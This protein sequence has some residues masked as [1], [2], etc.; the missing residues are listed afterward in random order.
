MAIDAENRERI[1]RNIKKLADGGA[2]REK[3]YEY[4]ASEGV[5]AEEVRAKKPGKRALKRSVFQ[6]IK[7]NL[8][9]VTASQFGERAITTGAQQR[10]GA[11]QGLRELAQGPY[12]AVLEAREALGLAEQGRAAD[13][14]RRVQEQRAGYQPQS[15]AESVSRFV[16]PTALTAPIPGGSAARAGLSGALFGGGQFVPEG[17]S[18]LGGAALGAGLGSAIQAGAQL[19]QK[20][21]PN[22][23]QTVRR[24]RNA[25]LE[26]SPGQATGFG[27]VQATEQ[28]LAKVPGSAGV[29]RRARE[30]Q[31]EQFAKQ[32]KAASD[33]LKGSEPSVSGA[34]IQ[35]GLFSEGGFVERQTRISNSLEAKIAKYVHPN[36]QTTMGETVK[37][38]DNLINIKP[39]APKT[40][41][42]LANQYLIKLRSDIDGDLAT[43][44]GTLDFETLRGLRRGVGERLGGPE[45]LREASKGQLAR[46]YKAMSDDMRETIAD[47]KGIAAWERM[48]KHWTGFRKRLDQTLDKIFKKAKPEEVYTSIRNDAKKGPTLLRRVKRSL[49][50]T[51]GVWDEF[52]GTVLDDL[53]RARA[54]SIS[55]YS[56]ETFLTNWRA[57]PAAAKSELFSGTKTLRL[58]SKKIDALAVTANDIRETSRVLFNPSGTAPSLASAAALGGGATAAALGE[59]G[60]AATL[61]GVVGGA[62][63]SARMWMSPRFVDY[64]TLITKN[65]DRASVNLA[66]FG[67]IYAAANSDLRTEFD[68]WLQALPAEVQAQMKLPN[69]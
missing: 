5:V 29:I 25:G 27:P 9:P 4:L 63:I 40:S 57:M 1:R 39:N 19:P 30:E 52:V 44:G 24:F 46:L 14:T 68:T 61:L 31:Q 64:L 21:F 11:T 23:G 45:S 47:P 58:L 13:Y 20:F 32:V 28:T 2:T 15:V 34:R 41:K 10:R 18:R 38:L 65:P 8:Q 49:K 35:R 51:P 36:A 7:E 48:N 3:V 54:G 42:R 55:E 16:A 50:D 6:Q 69:E 26:P 53:G 67:S 17:G 60:V 66:R 62:N 37:V 43:G 22:I 33:R 12:Q 56:T 59:P